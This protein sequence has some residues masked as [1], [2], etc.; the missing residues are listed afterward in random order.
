ML[1]T[2]RG[3]LAASGPGGR[4]LLTRLAGH[5]DRF[6]RWAASYDVSEIQAAVHGPVHQAVVDLT[7]SLH[8]RP[9]RILDAGC[10][11]GRLL[12]RAVDLFPG[13]LAVGLDLSAAMLQHCVAMP[14]PVTLVRARAERLPFR[15]GAFDLVVST[16][17][18]RRWS[19]P[20]AG[21]TELGRVCTPGGT[22]LIADAFALRPH[23]S[24]RIIRQPER[25]LRGAFATS[26]LELTRV[27]CEPGVLT[28]VAFL[29]GCKPPRNARSAALP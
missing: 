21:L 27:L 5:E 28:S 9:T 15:D 1:R 3:R 4:P 7:S 24:F 20:A 10:G 11:T 25:E 29:V 13:A 12:A 16:M 22:V 19:D 18:L 26:G 8:R 17:S 2:Q 14:R 6:D 23:R